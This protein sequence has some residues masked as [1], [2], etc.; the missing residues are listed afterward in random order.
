MLE[1]VT[2]S[3]HVSRIHGHA[4]LLLVGLG[5]EDGWLVHVT[6]D[7]IHVVGAL[8]DR[9]VEEIL[10]VVA[11]ALI[12][13]VNP[14]G[15][16]GT[17]LT[18]VSLL[19]TGVTDEQVGN[20]VVINGL[21]LLGETLLVHEVVIAGADV[22]IGGNDEATARSPDLVVHGHNVLLVE[23][24]LVEL[25]VL[26]VL[27]VLAVEP[28]VVDGEAEVVE[29][30]G[31]VSDPVGRVVLPLREVVSER[32][33]GRHAGVAGEL[34]KLL[35]ELFG[36]A[37]SAQKIEL[38]SVALGDE[39]VVSLL[40]VVTVVQENEGLSRVHPGDGGIALVRVAHDVGNG[41]VERLAVLAFLT[42][43]PSI[44][45]EETVG[46][47][48]AC[49][50][51]AEVISALRKTKHV[52][53]VDSEVKTNGV[54]LNDLAFLDRRAGVVRLAEVHAGVNISCRLATSEVEAWLEIS[55]EVSFVLLRHGLVDRNS[56][57]DTEILSI[58]VK[59]V[60]VVHN[61]GLVAVHVLHDSEWI[62][63]NLVRNLVLTADKDTVIEDLNEIREVLLNLDLIPRNTNAS[64]RD[65]EAL[66]FISGLDLDLHDTLLEESHVKIEVS[67]AELHTVLV[68]V[69]VLVEVKAGN[70]GILVDD[71]A[72]R[73]DEVGG[74]QMVAA[75]AVSKSSLVANEL[76]AVAAE[77]VAEACTVRALS[78]SGLVLVSPLSL[79]V[80]V[81][82]SLADIR[83]VIAIISIISLMRR[84]AL[85]HESLLVGVVGLLRSMD[86][87]V[88]SSGL[89]VV[90][91]TFCAV[92]R[93]DINRSL[94]SVVA[95]AVGWH[96][97]SRSAS[98]IED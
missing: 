58:V 80:T 45:V 65:G 68:E 77:H 32:G 75:H 85:V 74:R 71:N 8:E 55:R 90:Q 1:D 93:S 42:P 33:K 54:A 16:A 41:T 96:V 26:V 92:V 21:A 89:V 12:E 25:A 39:G 70:D 84:R 48:E 43:L 79:V 98:L 40:T 52:G 73:L 83:F 6:P 95:L 66:L 63:L 61:D 46:V 23:A 7:T 88:G 69:F 5:L 86:V 82:D 72:I 67:S 81:R 27:G 38:K 37:L 50:L 14:D 30:V 47:V 60:V 13:E 56:V 29:I 22:R 20:V 78:A 17:A 51:E 97:I 28:E 62:E 64:V 10:P 76:A 9:G 15:L 87:V 31:S 44:L 49:L 2:V 53:G 57:V 4:D 24:L 3:G 59:V 94:V 36:I 91:L 11:G 34:S 19:G 35:L 18:L